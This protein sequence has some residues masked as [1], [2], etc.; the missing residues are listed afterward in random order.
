MDVIHCSLPVSKHIVPVLHHFLL[1]FYI[2]VSVISG[3]ALL[4]TLILQLIKFYVANGVSNETMLEYDK[5][6]FYMF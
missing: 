3:L 5:E 2:M 4:L 1:R 6:S